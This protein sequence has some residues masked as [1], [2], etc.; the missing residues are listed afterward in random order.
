MPTALSPET[1]FTCLAPQLL[2]LLDNGPGDMS[3]AAAFVI[4]NGILGRR[5]YGAP[6]TI[7]WKL[8]AQPVLE[9]INPVSDITS[10]VTGMGGESNQPDLDSPIVDETDLQRA[11]NRLTTLTLPHPNPGLTKRLIGHVMLPLWGLLCYAKRVEKFGWYDQATKLLGRYWE[12]AADTRQVSKL[13]EQLLWSGGSSWTYGPGI[14]GGIE[15]RKRSNDEDG[16]Q[17]IVE[18]MQDVDN[19]VREF[20]RLLESSLRDD[21]SIGD[22]FLSVS[23]RWLLESSTPKQDGLK[24]EL[25]SNDEK[26]PL[27]TLVS[28]KLVQHML[29]KFKDKLAA[30]PDRILELVSQLL[31]EYVEKDQKSRSLA[32]ERTLGPSLAGLHNIVEKEGSQARYTGR[33]SPRLESEN[34]EDPTEIISI[35]LS[36]LSALLSSP[37]F[38]RGQKSSTLLSSM[39]LPLAYIATPTTSIPSSLSM[40]ATNLSSLFASEASVPMSSAT[41]PAI[42]PHSEDRK[43]QS[44]A[45]TYLTDPL[46]PVRNQG[47]SLLSNLIS[48]RS[49]V[50]D[51]PTTSVLL[52]SLLQDEDEFIYLNAIKSLSLLALKHPKTVVKILMARYVDQEEEMGLDQRLRLGEALLRTV[53]DLGE[54]VV[55]D[56]AKVVGQGLIDVAGRRGKRRKAE[57]EKHETAKQKKRKNEE[58]E[59]AWGGE[60]P[61]LGEDSEHDV[62]SEGIAKVVEGWEGKDAEEDVRIRTSALSVLGTA[63]E[64]NVAG[65][66]STITSTAVDVAIAILT[67]ESGDEKAILRRAAVLLILSLAKALEKARGEGR[68][69]AF[70]FAGESLEEVIRVLHYIEATDRDDLVKGHTAALIESLDAWKSRSFLDASDIDVSSPSA[71]IILGSEGLAGLSVTPNILSKSRPRVEEID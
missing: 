37:G 55:G 10:T 28:A 22:L 6:G 25:G 42:D 56:I 24:L 7:G 29:E 23:K 66:G 8:F 40:A 62:V 34:E 71:R 53:E 49:P 64:T 14:E 11:L 47:L 1:Y 41:Q 35:A 5:A 9:K 44:L 13:A 61:S 38:A 2:D 3:N 32:A 60:V 45:F 19:H 15:L 31:E 30:N 68:R 39:S 4:G 51:I 57:A 67:I 18:I 54:V 65:L 58:A 43:T 48:S 16:S 33:E 46:V 26:D 63:I 27:Q 52:L 69:L 50:L 12:V 21:Q 20:V 59:E 36:L 17:N 70:G